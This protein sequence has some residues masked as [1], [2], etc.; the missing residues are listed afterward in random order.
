MTLLRTC[1]LIFGMVALLGAEAKAVT[2]SL[3]PVADAFV[4]SANA[5]NNYGGAGSLQVSALGLPRGEFQSLVRFDLMDAKGNFDSTLG[6]G[7]WF[8]ESASLQLTSTVPNNPLFNATAAGVVAATWMQNDGW[9]EGAGT[10]M[11]PGA[12]GITWASLPTFQSA[13]DQPMGSFN[14]DGTTS[15]SNVYALT[16]ASGFLADVNAGD[17]SSILLRAADGDSD[18]SGLFSSR[19]NVTA[20]NRPVLILTAAAVPEPA[21]YW[22]IGVGFLASMFLGSARGRR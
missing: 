13:G 20:A 4:S 7:H 14:F 9:V 22:L 5:T 2:I 12:S 21:T 19:S 6:V 3:T 10:P 1:P 11:A 8:L 15:T 17:L 16:L 18:V